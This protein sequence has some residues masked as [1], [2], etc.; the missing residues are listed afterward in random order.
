MPSQNS[1]FK[2]GLILIIVLFSLLLTGYGTVPNF[3]NHIKSFFH[4]EVVFIYTSSNYP[5]EK[6]IKPNFNLSVE[7]L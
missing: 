2:K 7:R 4:E 3:R 6:N 1:Y 5:D